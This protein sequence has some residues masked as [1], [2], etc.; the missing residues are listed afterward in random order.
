MSALLSLFLFTAYAAQ[1]RKRPP[2]GAVF[3]GKG[4]IGFKISDLVGQL[5]RQKCGNKFKESLYN[6]KDTNVI[7][8]LEDV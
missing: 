7:S 8:R 1:L 6:Q 3:G 2:A 5:I 4:G